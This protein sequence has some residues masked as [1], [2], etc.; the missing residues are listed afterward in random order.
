MKATEKVSSCQQSCPFEVIQIGDRSQPNITSH[1]MQCQFLQGDGKSGF[2]LLEHLLIKQIRPFQRL[3][4]LVVYPAA[5]FPF[6]L[7]LSQASL[8]TELEKKSIIDSSQR[9]TTL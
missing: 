4:I 8:I 9:Q 5:L 1:H 2:Q 7:L 3:V 6:S